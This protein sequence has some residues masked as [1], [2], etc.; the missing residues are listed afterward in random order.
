MTMKK[1]MNKLVPVAVAGLVFA[2]A[3]TVEA[4]AA[5][6]ALPTLPEEEMESSE[7]NETS[8]APS[9][10]IQAAV[11]GDPKPVEG[12]GTETDVSVNP[13]YD[14]E[15]NTFTTDGSLTIKKDEDGGLEGITGTVTSPEVE[16]EFDEGEQERIEGEIQDA[17]DQLTGAE[18]GEADSEDGEADSEDGEA[19]SEAGPETAENTGSDEA[20]AETPAP[21]D[22]EEEKELEEDIKDEITEP[23][24]SLDWDIGGSLGGYQVDHSTRDEAD[25]TL[26]IYEL[27]KSETI[28]APLTIEELNELLGHELTKAEDNTYTYV[29]ADG[30]TVTVTVDDQSTETTRTRWVIYMKEVTTTVNSGEQTESIEPPVVPPVVEDIRP[31]LPAEPGEPSEP[32][33]PG[34]PGG[35]ETPPSIDASVKEALDALLNE[36]GGWKAG[37]EVMDERKDG[38]GKVTVVDGNKT[39]EFKYESSTVD[40]GSLTTDQIYSLLPN[41]SEY[42][43][44][45]GKIYKVIG[46]VKRELTFAETQAALQ[47]TTVTISMKV[48][49]KTPP[50][51]AVPPTDAEIDT[52]WDTSSRTAMEGAI[53]DAVHNVFD[54]SLTEGEIQAIKDTVKNLELSKDQGSVEVKVTVGGK[55]FNVTVNLMPSRAAGSPRMS[56][57][58][59]GWNR[60]S[61]TGRQT[62]S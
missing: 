45:D 48:T 19:D 42:S 16:V 28:S 1:H 24:G 51:E 52:A 33:E 12:G 14:P 30:V 43:L 34:E 60:E 38:V 37:L 53:L 31:A 62:S 25:G 35:A 29:N 2:G 20:K 4:S 47:K 39:Y 8:A 17:L 15:N 5:E 3:G 58:W 7:R 40:A 49:E 50:A 56:T 11:S 18:S 9:T 61:T 26:H 54:R 6:A 44:E 32:S 22:P 10:T 13:K 55:E 21:I 23:D 36:N 27:T 46:G 59:R 41:K 57:T